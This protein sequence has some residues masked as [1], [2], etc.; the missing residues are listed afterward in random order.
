[1]GPLKRRE[2]TGDYGKRQRIYFF[3]YK[4]KTL[5]SDVSYYYFSATVC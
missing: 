2:R 3:E 4:K 1:M 5:D